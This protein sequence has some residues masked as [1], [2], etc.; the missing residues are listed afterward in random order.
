MRAA[1]VVARLAGGEREFSKEELNRW[2]AGLRGQLML[3][4]SDGYEEAR[5]VW[6]AT[7]DKKPALIVRCAGV[8]DAVHTVRWAV[9]EGL[10]LSI[11]GGGHNVAGSAVC[12]GGV[13]L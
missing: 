4:R 10:L 11:R 7:V 12:D 9:S 2:S 6:N 5:C 3:P 13:V 8:A 1:A